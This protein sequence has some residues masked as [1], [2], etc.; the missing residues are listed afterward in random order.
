MRKVFT[1]FVQK[2]EEQYI[3]LDSST[4]S[5]AERY[6]K[7]YLAV[8]DRLEILPMQ[9]LVPH[10]WGGCIEWM[11]TPDLDREL[12]GVD[13]SVYF[14]LSEIP[15][16]GRWHQYLDVDDTC[17][18]RVLQEATPESIVGYV[19]L[20]PDINSE[21]MSRYDSIGSEPMS[22]NVF[23]GSSDTLLPREALLLST[24]SCIH[25]SFKK[26][27]DPFTLEWT[28]ESF[29]FQEIAF[30]LLSIAA[31]EVTFE[32][33]RAL[34]KTHE[35]EGYYILPDGCPLPC[36]L[37]E[38]HFPGVD[39]GSSP[40]NRTY[41][42]SN[43]LVHLSCRLD[44]VDVEKAAVIE[45][46]DAGLDQG[47]DEFYAMVFSIADVILVH[48]QRSDL[49]PLFYFDEESSRYLKGP[50]TRPIQDTQT[51]TPGTDANHALQRKIEKEDETSLFGEASDS[52]DEMET[53]VEDKHTKVDITFTSMIRFLDIA[54]RLY[55][56][57]ERSSRVP[58]EILTSIMHFTDTRTYR[59]L[60]NVS[61][62]C[63]KLSDR[64]FR[65]NDGYDVVGIEAQSVGSSRRFIIQDIHTKERLYS[66]LQHFNRDASDLFSSPDAPEDTLKLY[67]VIGEETTRRSIIHLTAL[68]FPMLPSKDMPCTNEVQMPIP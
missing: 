38:R 46:V 18:R 41:W 50:R 10:L 29:S 62:S 7:S 23:H 61:T 59:N 57:D 47:L 49:M 42:F 32:S 60:T 36:F 68:Q 66:E 26:L 33:I 30:A 22:S 4:S 2:L 24:F 31:G 58:N 65:L 16:G 11:Y 19:A 51:T 6:M 53:M 20:K 9:T 44:V 52:S 56:G 40:R 34:D 12:L 13:H 64:K 21:L 35:T 17:R 54:A 45:A 15:R 27:L 55:L 48:V 25:S 1:G 67:T 37:Y 3:P 63:R 14:K 43:I 8:D 28:P 39:P 5:L